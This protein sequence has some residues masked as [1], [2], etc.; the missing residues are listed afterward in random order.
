MKTRR[1]S[2]GLV[3]SLAGLGLAAGVYDFSAGHTARADSATDDGLPSVISFTAVIRDF[4]AA[5][6]SG[7]HADF[8]T[9]GNPDAVMGLVQ[10]KLDSEGKPVFASS[11][12]KAGCAGYKNAAGQRIMPGLYSQ[13]AGDTKGT[14]TDNTAKQLTSADAFKQWYRD[15]SGVNVSKSIAL[16]LNRVAGTKRYVFDSATDEPFKSVGGFFPINGDLFGNYSN[17]GKNFHFTTE[18]T[19]KF[20]YSKAEN[21]VFTFTGDDDLWVFID[22]KLVMDLGGLHSK[23]AQTLEVNRL[24]WLVDGKEYT[25]KIFHAERHTTQSNFRIET[26]LQL[27]PASLPPTSG[28]YD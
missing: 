4:K 20:V 17:T 7:G 16:K 22:G 12:G 8:E 1:T 11:F 26:S 24:N 15:T 28:L 5:A 21:A 10:D 14:L 25:L 18:V 3:L 23:Q 6:E 2:K 27:V 13:S 19:A 9:Y